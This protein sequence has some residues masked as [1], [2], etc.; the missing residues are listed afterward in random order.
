MANVTNEVF[1]DRFNQ[2][3]WEWHCPKC[4]FHWRRYAGKE[5]WLD[6]L[7]WKPKGIT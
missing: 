7:Q 3:G 4:G 6:G 2:T 1:D 5:E